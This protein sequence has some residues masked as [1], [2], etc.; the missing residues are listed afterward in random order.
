MTPPLFVTLPHDT[1][2]MTLHH[3]MILGRAVTQYPDNVTNDMARNGATHYAVV[4]GRVKPYHL[5]A[6]DGA[7][8]EPHPTFQAE[9]HCKS[10]AC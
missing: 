5:T 2:F 7:R 3:D 4:R 9:Q 1:A 8:R 10:G 6:C